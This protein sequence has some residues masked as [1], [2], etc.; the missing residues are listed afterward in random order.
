MHGPTFEV[1]TDNNP[2]TCV[3]TTAKLNAAGLRWVTEFANFKFRVHYRSDAKKKDVDYLLR[4]STAEIEQLES[5]NHS[6][7]DSD[8]MRLL[9]SSI[10]TTHPPSINVDINVLQL[11]NFDNITSITKTQ[12]IDSQQQDTSIKPVYQFVQ[13]NIKPSKKEMEQSKSLQ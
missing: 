3:L 10:N 8:N 5:E 12:L 2:L 9:S 7:I 4:H 6:I 1:C 11:P 13:L